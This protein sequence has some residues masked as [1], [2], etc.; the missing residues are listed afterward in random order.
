MRYFLHYDPRTALR[1]VH[2]PVL[3]M[4]GALDVQVPAEPNLT[5]IDAA[6]R[7]AGN[8]NYQIVQF[9]GLNHLFQTATTGSP[10]E[11]ATIRETIA[12]A[13]LDTIASFVNRRFET[14]A[15]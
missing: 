10:T 9:P 3:A 4:G 15:P 8:R 2:V 6:L 14:R 12:P 1:Q 13:V 11:Y 7:T 5:E